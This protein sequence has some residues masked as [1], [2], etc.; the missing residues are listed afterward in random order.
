VRIRI[1][2]DRGRDENGNTII[3][4]TR[5]KG[6]HGYETAWLQTGYDSAEKA[7]R[8]LA[9][10]HAHDMP[11]APAVV[12]IETDV[13]PGRVTY[14]AL[15]ELDPTSTAAAEIVAAGGFVTEGGAS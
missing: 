13:E 9:R 8:E 10:K 1:D 2:I 7:G 15:P 3:K 11:G 6:T 12:W 5:R 4:A 14:T